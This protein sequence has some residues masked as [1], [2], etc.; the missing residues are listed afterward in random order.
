MCGPLT[1]SDARHLYT[2]SC[3]LPQLAVIAS[4]GGRPANSCGRFAARRSGLASGLALTVRQARRVGRGSARKGGS[5]RCFLRSGFCGAVRKD[6]WVPLRVEGPT[7]T[8]RGVPAPVTVTFH[9]ATGAPGANVTAWSCSCG[10]APG[11]YG[12]GWLR[13]VAGQ[14]CAAA[15]APVGLPPGRA[16]AKLP[17][18]NGEAPGN[19]GRLRPVVPVAHGLLGCSH[20]LTEPGLG[21]QAWRAEGAP[22]KTTYRK[23]SQRVHYLCSLPTGSRIGHLETHNANGRPADAL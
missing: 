19:L 11:R 16:R 7:R 18:R 5:R 4:A 9:P 22:L 15:A 6:L 14:P 2:M 17:P 12:G 10:A 21:R 1:L 20:L 3:G 23:S 8:M 13:P